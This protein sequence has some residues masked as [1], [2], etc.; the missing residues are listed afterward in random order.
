MK[1][2][3]TFEQIT[4]YT[5]GTPNGMAGTFNPDSDWKKIESPLNNGEVRR[6]LDDVKKDFKKKKRKKR[7]L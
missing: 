2:L 7:S 6:I 5:Q 4:D 3:L 1:Y